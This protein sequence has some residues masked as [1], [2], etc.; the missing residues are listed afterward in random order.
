MAGP[1]FAGRSVPAAALRAI[2]GGL[3]ALLE[4]GVAVVLEGARLVI[5][6]ESRCAPP[7]GGAVE[8]RRLQRCACGAV[9]LAGERYLVFDTGGEPVPTRPRL[10]E[11]LTRREMEVAHRIACGATNKDIARGLGISPFTVREHVRRIGHKLSAPSRSRIAAVVG[12]ARL[13]T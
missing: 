3:D 1:A 5:V 11:V 13:S 9:V 10:G 12:E 8:R 6:A 2:G 7:A 4:V